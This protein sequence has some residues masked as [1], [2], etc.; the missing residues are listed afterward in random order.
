MMPPPLGRKNGVM[1]RYGEA[2]GYAGFNDAAPIGAEEPAGLRH[3]QGA[4][5][6]ASMMPPPL[7]RKNAL[8][9]LRELS[10]AA[11]AS[12]MPP[13]LGRKNESPEELLA[14]LDSPLQ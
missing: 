14:A 7:G 10:P 2:I 11:Y 9:A 1:G 13:P 8:G 12:M 5:A 6:P 3:R 4:H